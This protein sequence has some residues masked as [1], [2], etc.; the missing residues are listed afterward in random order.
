MLTP[1][2]DCIAQFQGF[3][4]TV[5]S[6]CSFEKEGAGKNI[7][8]EH[9]WQNIG[10]FGPAQ[11]FVTLINRVVGTT[12]QQRRRSLTARLTI[13]I[14]FTCGDKLHFSLKILSKMQPLPPVWGKSISAICWPYCSTVLCERPGDLRVKKRGQTQN[15]PQSAIS[16]D[17]LG[18]P[19]VHWTAPCPQLF[20]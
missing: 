9:T 7:T 13:R 14:L 20:I 16:S 5:S 8:S 6:S 19:N 12:T 17:T 10:I 3:E 2:V 11:R 15:P 18:M 4:L 1:I